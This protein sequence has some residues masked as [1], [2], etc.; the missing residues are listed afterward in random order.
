[1]LTPLLWL[2][3]LMQASRGAVKVTIVTAE[4]LKKKQLETIQQAVQDFV[5]AGKVVSAPAL[6]LCVPSAV[7]MPLHAP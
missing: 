5:G 4:A 1:V 3:E 7:C 6:R 2:L